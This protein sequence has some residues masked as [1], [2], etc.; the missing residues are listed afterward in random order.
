[1][2]AVRDAVPG[3]DAAACL[4]IYGP[5][6]R[7]SVVS[8][9]EEVPTREAFAERMRAFAATHA[10]LVLEGENGIAGFAYGS[11][12]RSRAAYRWAADVTVYVAPHRQR[13]GIGRRLYSALLERLAAQGYQVACAGIT[14]PNDASVGLHRALGFEPVGVYRRIGWKAGA[15]HDVGWWQCELV[16]AGSGRPPEPRALRAPAGE[17]PPRGSPRRSGP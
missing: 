4:E 13:S 2:E 10:W 16:A 8:F 17:P 11:P 1:M 9:E 12:H 15:W 3:A 7:D 5:Y 14:L 6:V